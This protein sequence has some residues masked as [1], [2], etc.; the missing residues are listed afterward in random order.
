MYFVRT[1]YIIKKLFPQLI[2]DLPNAENKVYLTF[3]D[4][5]HP[6]I[7]PW[8][9]E[10][11]KKYDA[12]ATFFC[13]G[14]N[15]KK[16]PEIIEQILKEGHQIGNHGYAH[17]NGWE[18][19]NDNYLQDYLKCQDL[20][21]QVT[22]SD[23][24]IF[25]PAYGKVKKYQILRIKSHISNHKSEI[26]NWSLM[27]GDFDQNQTSA[28][29]FSNLKKVKSGD[30]V[31]MHDNEKSWKHLEYSLPKFLEF[32]KEEKYNLYKIDL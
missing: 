19:D 20:L 31:V 25:R 8:I 30:I 23:N 18:T 6:E 1:P 29:C 4:G 7:T 24:N 5:P 13:L 15:V 14:E 3:D 28:Q 9:L 12:K 16:Y 22:N 32:C 21:K 10:Q 26:I 2:W 17:L 27:A 11:L